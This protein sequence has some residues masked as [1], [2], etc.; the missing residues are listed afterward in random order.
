[1]Y[2]GLKVFSEKF[3]FLIGAGKKIIFHNDCLKTRISFL[4]VL[5]LFFLRE[6]II[7]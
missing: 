4:F 6:I 2:E 5:T 7:V 1:L 3:S